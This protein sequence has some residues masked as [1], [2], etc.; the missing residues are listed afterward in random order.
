[1]MNEAGSWWTVHPD[2]EAACAD[3][4]FR[5]G[6]A[7]RCPPNGGNAA[8]RLKMYQVDD[9]S[10]II[11]RENTRGRWAN[12]R[13]YARRRPQERC[14]VPKKQSVPL[15]PSSISLFSTKP[16]SQFITKHT[17]S[18]NPQRGDHLVVDHEE[19]VS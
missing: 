11:Y 10:E 18:V 14:V 17:T 2:C 5:P 1:M 3:E 12:E 16:S 6:L 9:T 7:H 4:V 19:E 15:R 8:S 13:I